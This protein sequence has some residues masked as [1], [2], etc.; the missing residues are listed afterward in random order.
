MKR[1][2]RVLLEAGVLGAGLSL[3]IITLSGATRD[4]AVALSIASVAL[5][6][7]SQLLNDE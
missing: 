5:F 7:G 1:V 2:T 6:L 3:V 4:A